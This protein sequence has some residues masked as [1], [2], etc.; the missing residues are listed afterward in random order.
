MSS[1]FL[2]ALRVSVYANMEALLISLA[3]AV[4]MH[5]KVFEPSDL[6]KFGRLLVKLIFPIFTFSVSRA[7]LSRGPASV[8]E[9]AR[10]PTPSPC[11]WIPTDILTFAS[12]C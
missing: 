6:K 12:L 11:P 5:L 3:G 2:E 7:A 9:Y 8:H 4:G 10:Q 1:L